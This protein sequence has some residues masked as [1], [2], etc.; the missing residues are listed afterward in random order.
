MLIDFSLSY[1]GDRWKDVYRQ[2]DYG[3]MADLL[4]INEYDDKSDGVSLDL[5]LEHYEPR[6]KWDLWATSRAMD[7]KKPWAPPGY[8]Y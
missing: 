7:R 6:E 3:E 8:F 4:M 1:R 5:L 2:D